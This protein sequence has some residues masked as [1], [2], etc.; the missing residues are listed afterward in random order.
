VDVRVIAATN[1]DLVQRIADGSFREDLWYRLNVVPIEMPALRDRKADI[2]ALAH[3]FAAMFAAQQGREVPDL[4]PSLLAV[5]M[6]SDWPGNVREL[7]NYIERLMAMTPGRS[8]HPKPLPHDLERRLHGRI[9][10]QRDQPLG[11][12][13]AELERRQVQRALERNHGNQSKA[14]RELGLTEQSLRYRLRKY[15]IIKDRRFRRSR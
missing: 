7:Q 5:L 12:Q 4:S 10:V 14:A 11:E 9:H 8:L 3:H 2:P 15:A 13:V 1:R 6:Q